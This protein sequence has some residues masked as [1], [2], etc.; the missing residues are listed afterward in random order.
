MDPTAVFEIRRQPSSY[1]EPKH[2]KQATKLTAIKQ[3][4]SVTEK[5]EPQKSPN[6]D[7]INSDS[8]Y[9]TPDGIQGL[10]LDSGTIAINT[11]HDLKL[12]AEYDEVPGTSLELKQLPEQN[13]EFEGSYHMLEETNLSPSHIASVPNEYYN[14][15]LNEEPTLDIHQT[16]SDRPPAKAKTLAPA[17][18]HA[19]YELPLDPSKSQT[20]PANFTV[21]ASFLDDYETPLDATEK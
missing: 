9:D 18:T 5:A 13:N 20:I 6:Y 11:L 19:D 10:T 7:N 17:T 14:S 21:P 3:L 2:L 1:E 16:F 15:P 4:Q 12:P 8:N